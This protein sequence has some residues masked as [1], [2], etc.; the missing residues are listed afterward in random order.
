LPV[1][2]RSPPAL[3]QWRLIHRVSPV[4]P[5]LAKQA[6]IQGTVRMAVLIDENGIVDRLKLIGGH[7]L[8]VNAAFEAVKQWRY[9]PATRGG[10]RVAAITTIEITFTLGDWL[11]APDKS[12]GTVSRGTSSCEAIRPARMS[13]SA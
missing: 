6:R 13:A 1:F 11:P 5:A 2:W 4:Y 3:Q 8:L 9:R 10:V 7:P 12:K